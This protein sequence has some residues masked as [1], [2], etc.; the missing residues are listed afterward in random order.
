MAGI[1]SFEVDVE[2]VREGSA[3]SPA[4]VS[5]RTIMERHS[6]LKGIPL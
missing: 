4:A 5:A 3:R 6:H 2:A 1:L